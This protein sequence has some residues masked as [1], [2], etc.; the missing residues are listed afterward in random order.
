MELLRSFN[1]AEALAAAI[2]HT[3]CADIRAPGTN[4]TACGQVFGPSSQRINTVINS[5]RSMQGDNADLE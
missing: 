2:W 1:F 5:V 3:H 4:C